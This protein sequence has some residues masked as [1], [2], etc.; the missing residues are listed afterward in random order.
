[1]RT[2]GAFLP[3]LGRRVGRDAGWAVEA[4]RKSDRGSARIIPWNK[5]ASTAPREVWIDHK[6]R[7]PTLAGSLLEALERSKKILDLPEDW[8]DAGNRTF[9]F[10]TWERM[11]QLLVTHAALVWQRTG[12]IIPVPRIMPGPE[13][14]IDLHWKTSRREL[15]LNVPEDA[16]KAATYY[17]D[18]F[19][20]EEITGPDRPVFPLGFL[21]RRLDVP[22]GR[23]QQQV[24][25][26]LQPAA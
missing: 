15:L 4:P 2:S 22:E 16:A 23:Q 5:S 3:S 13:G 9:L 25:E 10:E 11:R 12:L 17:C 18:D 19:G 14:S 1:M 26:N 24:V 21:F 6:Q 20:Q 8:D 7:Q